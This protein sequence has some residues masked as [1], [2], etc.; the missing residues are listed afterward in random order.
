MAAMLKNNMARWS[1]CKPLWWKTNI[2][3]TDYYKMRFQTAVNDMHPCMKSKSNM[4]KK[5]QLFLAFSKYKIWVCWG[6]GLW[7]FGWLKREKKKPPLSEAA[8][9][10]GVQVDKWKQRMKMTWVKRK[11]KNVRHLPCTWTHKNRKH[12]FP[13]CKAYLVE[14]TWRSFLFVGGFFTRLPAEYQ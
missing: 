1:E 13:V 12:N 4:T 9:A 2:S 10:I 7:M 6:T 14:V 11:T 8:N 5:A 3:N